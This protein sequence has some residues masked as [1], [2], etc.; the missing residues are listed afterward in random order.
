MVG[1]LKNEENALDA[2]LTAHPVVGPGGTIA[3]EAGPRPCPRTAVRFGIAHLD[4][5]GAA[6]PDFGI[7]G[8]ARG[9]FSSETVE[10]DGSTVA[11]EPKIRG[12][13]EPL[14]AVLKRM[15]PNGAPDPSFGHGGSTTLV[16]RGGRRTLLSAVGADSAGRVLVAGAIAPEPRRG[17]WQR[18]AS[19]H[20][21][22]RLL[23]ERL[24][25]SGQP[26][27]AFGPRGQITPRFKSL[28]VGPPTL[29]IDQQGRALLVS[30]YRGRKRGVEG[31]A[32]A[33]F[34]L[35]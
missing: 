10:P 33:R 5:A 8:A 1:G 22:S 3:F 13:R 31:L 34:V 30:R 20:L 14:R 26:D 18:K 27:S 24:T 17:K 29:L 12:D 16:V 4:E 21:Q 9:Y 25:P 23:L 6:Q 35:R 7:E 19:N 2:E 11:L 32:V 28:R 15:Q